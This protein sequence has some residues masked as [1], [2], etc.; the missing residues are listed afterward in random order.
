MDNEKLKKKMEEVFKCVGFKVIKINNTNFY[1]NKNC[2]CKLTYLKSLSAF[3][4]ESADSYQ[5]AE[6]GV[7][8]DGEIYFISIPETDLLLKLK[9]DLLNYYVSAD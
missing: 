8:E 2:Y 6:A 1:V 3:V 5:E 9:E 7:L 4:I